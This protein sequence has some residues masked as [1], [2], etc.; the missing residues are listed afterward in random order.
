MQV[1]T[2]EMISAKL[3]SAR[4]RPTRQRVSLAQLLFANG[5]RHFTAEELHAEAL[6]AD[7]RVSLATIYN[8]LNQFTDAGL[9]REVAT[10]GHKSHFD[11]NTSNHHHFYIE[12]E[13]RLVDIPEGALRMAELPEPLEGKRIS[14]IDIIVR[15]QEC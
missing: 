2:K 9:L 13:D 1:A 11:T 8:T 5:N 10:E 14:G 4:L 3:R 6:D 12:S 15:L 7:V